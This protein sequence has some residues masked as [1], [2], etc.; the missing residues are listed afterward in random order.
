MKP[1]ISY[2]GSLLITAI[3][4]AQLTF[5]AENTTSL[6]SYSQQSEHIPLPKEVNQP[7]TWIKSMQLDNGLI[8]SAQGTDFVSLYD[9]ALA[10]I[11]FTLYEDRRST[12]MILDYFN[13]RLDT[14]FI[15]LGGGFYQFRT[16]DGSNARRKW[17]G[18]NAWLLIAIQHYALRFDS[19]RYTAMAKALEHWLRSQQDED[20]GLW[21]GIQANGDRIH[22]ITEGIITVFNAI[23][24]YDEFHKGILKYIKDHR[25]D[26]QE[27][28][29]LAWP[30]NQ[31]YKFAMDLHALGSLIFP[32][33]SDQLLSKV[34]RYDT[35]K[36][37]SSNGIRI[38]GFCFDEDKDVIWLEGTAQMALAFRRSGKEDEGLAMIREVHKSRIRSGDIKDST[39]IPYTVNQGSSYGPEKLWAHADITPAISSSAWYIFA[40]VNFNPFELEDQKDIPQADQFWMP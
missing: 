9:N 11:V 4:S 19:T 14:E 8:E 32:S 12:E 1:Q 18:D 21:G 30:E 15:E 29:L 7:Y 28:L 25:W 27:N 6:F 40:Q 13:E 20:G 35:Q 33:M 16:A 26:R 23:E 38:T 34:G 10:A 2:L 39:G 22:K 17:I 5:A 37:A 31:K 3:F 24:G 36:N